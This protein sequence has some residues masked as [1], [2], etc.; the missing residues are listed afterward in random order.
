MAAYFGSF[1]G[2]VCVRKRVFRDSRDAAA[3]DDDGGGGDSNGA[4]GSGW[5]F[6]GSVF[7]TFEDAGAARAVVEG[8][9]LNFGGD[10]LR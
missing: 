10:K 1:P 3:S 9:A 7:V 2:S 5:R 6:T 4:S 8:G